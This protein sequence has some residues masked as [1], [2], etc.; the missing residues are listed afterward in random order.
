MAQVHK[1]FSDSQVKEMI[2][3]Y[4]AKEIKR[5]HMQTVLGIKRRRFCELVKKYK[6]N[7]ESF[8]VEYKRKSATR[9]ITGDVEENI[10]LELLK[11][12]NLIDDPEV[13]IRNYNYSYIKDRLEEK[14]ANKVSLPTIIS[15]AK[16]YN[17]YISKRKKGKTHEREVITDYAGQLIQH[18]SSHHKWS[19]Y[20]DNKW[21]LITSLDDFSRYILYAKLVEKETSWAHIAAMEQLILKYGLPYSYYVDSHSIFRFVQGRDS[22][23]R[24]H[25]SLTDDENPQ[26]KQILLELGVKIEYALSPQAKGKVERPYEWLQDR[27]VRIC[28]REGIKDILDANKVLGYE[29]KRCNYKQ[30]HSTTGEVPYYRFSEALSEGTSLFRQFVLLPPYTSTKD[31]FALRANRIID[32]Y[33]KISINNLEI[34]LN[35][36]PRDYVNMRIYP[37]N[38]EFSEVRFWCND[39]LIEVKEIRNSDLRIVHF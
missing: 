13:P 32:P 21:Y 18:D 2:A 38:K 19:P 4:L 27:I 22:L 15:R 23:Y 1:K 7:P 28:A 24:K 11:E 17:F 30:V 29:I 31:I 36:K 16:K 9:A 26:W 14:Y 35:G 34:K 20:A 5:E 33:R 25:Y 12:K 3:R 6:D 10:M 39:K 8:S 37:L